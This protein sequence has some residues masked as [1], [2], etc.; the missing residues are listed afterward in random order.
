MTT[1]QPPRLE[2]ATGPTIY[3]IGVT[4]GRSSILKVFPRWAEALGLADARIVGIDLPLHAPAEDYRSVVSFIR[5]D[6]RSRGALVTTHKI[7]L[8]EACSDL[9]DE[10]D[11]LAR[12]TGKLSCLSKRDGRL[13]GTAKDPI[14]GGLAL[15]SFVPTGHFARTDADAFFIGAGGAAIAI[16]WS[17]MRSERG[18]DRPSRIVVSD[19]D[20]SRL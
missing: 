16:T 9:F 6:P 1:A 17:L 2:P 8:L 18:D 11:E 19:R 5:D 12:L 3:F 15:D 20:R 13:I 10:I 4:T 7:D 14:T